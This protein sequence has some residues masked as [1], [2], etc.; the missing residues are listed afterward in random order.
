MLVLGGGEARQS[1]VT[2]ASIR[3]KGMKGKLSA[4]IAVRTLT[5][6]LMF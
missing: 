3:K 6:P 1:E 4:V 5:F 2:R